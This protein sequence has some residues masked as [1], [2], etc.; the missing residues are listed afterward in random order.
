MKGIASLAGVMLAVGALSGPGSGVAAA[1]TGST[2]TIYEQTVFGAAHQPAGGTFTA[3]GLPACAS[4]TFSDRPVSFSPSGARLIL[5][6]T[7]TCVEGGNFSVRVALHLSVVDASGDQTVDGT[8]RITS[9]DGA[10][11]G[12]QGSGSGAGLNTG[13]SPVGSIFAQCIASSGTT[14]ASIH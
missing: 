3:A 13:C 8:W 1:V 11:T 5:D 6:R 9:S 2:A 4:G 10:L 12:L 7:Y 14:T